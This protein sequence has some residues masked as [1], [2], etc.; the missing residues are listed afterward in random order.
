MP[1]LDD[2]LKTQVKLN[3]TPLYLLEYVY[4]ESLC[5][6]RGNVGG[7]ECIYYNGM[8]LSIL[9]TTRPSLSEKRAQR[10]H[11]ASCVVLLLEDIVTALHA[12]NP[13]RPCHVHSVT[14]SSKNTSSLSNAPGFNQSDVHSTISSFLSLPVLPLFSSSLPLAAPLIE[15]LIVIPRATE[16]SGDEFDQDH[17]LNCT[18]QLASLLYKS[19]I[20]CIRKCTT[21]HNSISWPLLPELT[22]KGSV[23]APD[24]IVKVTN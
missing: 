16:T 17:F 6:S 14:T 24:H 20:R 22:T 10:H 3:L 12:P 13:K 19:T 18:L 11:I 2:K 4:D 1:L 21:L 15:C 5:L 23:L 7:K 9:N 8:Q